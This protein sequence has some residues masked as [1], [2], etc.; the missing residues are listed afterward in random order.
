MSTQDY[1][2][3][4]SDTQI[5]IDWLDAD[6]IIILCGD[7]NGQIGVQWGSHVMG[8]VNSR[9]SIL[10]DFMVTNNMYSAISHAS[11][12]GPVYTCLPGD[13]SYNPSQ[14]DHFII[15][16]D[17]MSCVKQC[18]VHE[19]HDAN[20]SDHLPITLRVECD[21][22]PVHTSTPRDRYNWDKCDKPVY[23]QTLRTAL[24]DLS[25]QRINCVDDIDIY[26]SRLQTIIKSTLDKCVPK[27]RYRAYVRPYW[28]DN[29]TVFHR[30]QSA[31]RTL[32][33]KAGRPRGHQYG[34]YYNYKVAKRKF[35]N[36]LKATQLEYYQKEYDDIEQSIDTDVKLLWRKVKPKVN[37]GS[38]SHIC[39]E[40]IT[41]NS[42]TELCNL[43]EHYY[44]TLLN[45]QQ[46]EST[47][48]DNEH[49][50]YVSSS[51]EHFRNNF[52]K[53]KDNSGVLSVAFTIN[54]IATICKALPTGK[55]P[56]YDMIMNECLKYGGYSLYEV[57][58]HMYNSV[59]HHGYIPAALK[60]SII[61]PLY[62]GKQKPKMNLNSYRGISLTPT[63]NKVLEKLILTRLNPWLRARDFP[64][65]LQ[66]AGR[67][68][69]NCVGLAYAV[70]E[71][72]QHMTFQ[73]SKVYGCFLDIQSAYDVVNWNSLLYKMAKIGICDKM[74]HFFKSWL[75][76]STSQIQVH[77]QLS[78]AFGVTR[79]IKQGGLL[80]TL[81]F[82][83]FYHDIH[84]YVRKGS[85]QS[86]IFHG[87]DIA[88]PTMA[89]DTL[90]LSSTV[91]G[92]QTMI[93][94]AYIYSRRWRFSYSPT[95][96][97]CITFGENK[98]VHN[99][100]KHK[101]QWTMNDT[102]LE[103]VDSYIYLGILLFS[104]GLS[105]QRTKSMSRKGYCSYGLLKSV[106]AHANGMSP[107][108]CSKLW[109]KMTLPSILYGERDMGPPASN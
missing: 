47:L 104:D 45:E 96:T 36:L 24:I 49:C 30:E 26:L 10:S 84:E 17:N 97:K 60:H 89:D 46:N 40:G 28:N 63:I 33:I 21:F 105:L 94:N 76:G 102:I 100:N 43:W 29:L 7:F 2:D 109:H 59:V 55:A 31:C 92:L 101:R 93:A 106:G 5:I 78:S 67:K 39:H 44:K 85:T 69:T 25:H 71:A 95:K 38:S 72:I 80:S 41:Y 70:K 52:S 35:T 18:Y 16:T 48:Y 68:G 53:V 99:T 3:C 54:E 22:T 12:S 23:T 13:A 103:E 27:R 42:P 51:V 66:Q 88:S 77:G 1:R 8:S 91:N 90:L 14:L 6:G 15:K 79:S 86:L 50:D 75:E 20:M 82:I 81:Y 61:I 11:C 58:W 64:P 19:E 83:L 56:G 57:L 87:R 62:K 74:W 108:T 9:G 98:R 32:W 4:L 34:T 37:S 73:S 65:P 107:I